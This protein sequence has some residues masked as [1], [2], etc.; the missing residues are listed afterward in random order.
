MRGDVWKQE[1]EQSLG[2]SGDDACGPQRAMVMVMA[3]EWSGRA[4]WNARLPQQSRSLAQ[5]DRCD[6]G[7]MHRYTAGTT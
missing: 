6:D 5:M 1:E 7:R 3:K 4:G 2:G